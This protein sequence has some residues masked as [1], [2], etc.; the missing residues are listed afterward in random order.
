MGTLASHSGTVTTLPVKDYVAGLAGRFT[1]VVYIGSTYDEPLPRA[2]IDDTLTGNVPVM[3]SGFNIWQLTK[4]DADRAAFTQ[5]Y[6]WDAATSYIDSTD[7]VTKISYNGA[8]LKRNELNSGGII[9]PH[10]TREKDVKVLGL[11][12]IH[13]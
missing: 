6:G 11:S 13:I 10:I 5:R 9:A 8:S 7:R 3:W 4:T 12:L 2:F 1:N